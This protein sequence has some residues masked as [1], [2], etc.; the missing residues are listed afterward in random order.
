M[1]RLTLTF[2]SVAAAAFSSGALAQSTLTLFGVV[3][4]AVQHI[5]GGDAQVTRL[6]SGALNGS[7]LGFKGVEDLGGGLSASFHLEAG[8]NTDSGSGRRT[9]TDN[10]TNT[11]GQAITFNRRSTVGLKGGFGEVRLGRDYTPVADNHTDYDVFG[12]SGIGDS[13]LLTQAL[14][15]GLVAGNGVKTDV[16]ASN[17][18]GYFLPGN[19]GGVYGYAMHAISETTNGAPE[20][21]RKGDGAHTGARIGYESGGLNV[22]VAYGKTKLASQE[23]LDNVH[24][25][26]WYK[27]SPI[28]IFGQISRERTRIGG[29]RHV[30][31]AGSIGAIYVQ[32]VNQFKA[33]ITRSV[34]QG[35]SG[36]DAAAT[37]L[38][39]GYQYDLSKRTALHGAVAFIRNNDRGIFDLAVPVRAGQNA[40]GVQVGVRHRF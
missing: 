35:P 31:D 5:K 26:A 22:A 21:F 12:N 23:G 34:I 1:R 14:A 3:D 39:L 2:V 29:Q 11:A 28:Q 18:I 25:G 9:S 24:L 10:V 17:S 4:T 38:A 20:G 37:M 19:L 40:S 15:I 33:E 7:R 13:S 6:S 32:G 8:L 16:R 27:M 36:G 30:N